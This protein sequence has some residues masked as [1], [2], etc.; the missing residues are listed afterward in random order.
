MPYIHGLTFVCEICGKTVLRGSNV[1]QVLAETCVSDGNGGGTQTPDDQKVIFAMFHTECVASTY[2][3]RECDVIAYV[4][5]AREVIEG[6][7][8]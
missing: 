5:E 1:T 3:A 8:A 6:E 2:A 4:D 7:T